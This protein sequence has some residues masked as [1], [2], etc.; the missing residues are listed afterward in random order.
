MKKILRI[1]IAAGEVS[2]DILGAGLIKALQ[3]YC[4]DAQFEGI[5]GPKMIAC[6]FRTLV[7]MERLSVM[8][9]I[10]PLG[11][12][13]ELLR[14]KRDLQNHFI[15]SPP[16]VFIGIDSPGFN[17]RVERVLHDHGIRTVHYVSPSVWAWGE[18][19]IYD[20]A[21][22]VD[23]VLTLFPFETAVYEQNHIGV[24]FIGH[25]LADQI[26][27]QADDR[28]EKLQARAE[29]G[30]SPDATVLALLPGSRKDEISRLG[31]LFLR[32]ARQ[33]L[34]KNPELHF[35]LPC[36]NAERRLQLNEILAEENIFDG[37]NKHFHLV[38]GNSHGA[39]RAADLVVLA[40]GTATLEAMLLKRP[41]IICYRLAPLT[42]MLAKRLV[43]VK[44]VGLP[45]LLAREPLVP[46]LL[47]NKATV[48]ELT[49]AIER[50]LLDTAQQQYVL[51]R[52][53]EIHQQIRCD[54]SAQAAIAVLKL[55]T[56][57]SASDATATVPS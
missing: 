54:A 11:R 56:G 44:Y 45:N 29:L 40:S 38:D 31:K 2:G 46:E 37:F 21:Q 4:P 52:F 27:P 9:F 22:A 5:G 25:P 19:R 26:D 43:K 28:S 41:M 10:E 16:D 53:T 32:T 55:I 6:G 18:K 47:Q 15:E 33:C 50:L 17:L 30:I 42:W 20:I 1:G 49:A 14:I 51:R 8:G 23:L 36:A 13:P 35:V 24:R 3:Q 39:M 34:L 12:L 48:S 57:E 7:P